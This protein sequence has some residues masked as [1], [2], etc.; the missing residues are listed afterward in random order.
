MASRDIEVQK[1]KELQTKE[2][3]TAQARQYLPQTDIYETDETL[4][5]TMEMPGVDKKD[6]SAHVENNVLRVEGRLD[7]SKF[8]GMEPVYAEYNVGNF[9]RTFS[10]SSRIAQDG[11]SAELADGVLTLT[12]AKAQEAKPRQIQIS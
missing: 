3:K 1:K 12:L 9:V 11:I 6:V 7:F 4:V 8:D 2:E 5:V 10:L